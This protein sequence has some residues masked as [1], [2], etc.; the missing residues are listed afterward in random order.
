M[1]HKITAEKMNVKTRY[2]IDFIT[3]FTKETQSQ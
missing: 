2:L 3:Q 1:N